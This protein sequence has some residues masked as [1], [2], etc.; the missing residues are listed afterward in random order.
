MYV[1]IDFQAALD[2]TLT[3]LQR[4]ERHGTPPVFG[5]AS[6][7]A[8][9]DGHPL[10]VASVYRAAIMW[11]FANDVDGERMKAAAVDVSQARDW[12]S[13]ARQVRNH[14]DAVRSGAHIE[15]RSA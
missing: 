2:G 3:T 1:V 6:W 7:T 10:R 5:S 12:A 15:R 13:E 8:L 11:V 14:A 4:L 9:P